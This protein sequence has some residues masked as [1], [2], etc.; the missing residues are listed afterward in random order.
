MSFFST[1]PQ[2]LSRITSGGRFIGEVDGLRFL[3]IFPV[4]VQHLSERLQRYGNADFENVKELSFAA[5]TASRGFIGV[6]IFFA[7]SGFILALPFANHY[8]NDTRK[9]RLK[10]YFV[11]RL[12]RLEPPYIFFMTL[13]FLI[14]LVMNRYPLQ[15]LFPHYLASIFYVHNLVYDAYSMI[16][17][18]AWTLEIEVQ[19]YI[20]APLLAAVF[21]RLKS[22]FLRRL[23]LV[24]SIFVLLTAQLYFGW[25]HMP[26][27]ITLLNNLHLFLTGFLVAD[28]YVKT[29]S[30]F[31]SKS[32]WF[33]LLF[34]LVLPPLFF[35]WGYEAEKWYLFPFLLF[36]V[37]ISVFKSK[38]VNRF[39]TNPWIM[40]TGG[41]CYTIYLIHLPL[42]EFQIRLTKNLII[43]DVFWVNLLVQLLIYLPLV[44][45]VS[46]VFFLLIEKPCMDKEW[47]QKL[48][49][50]LQGNKVI[51]KPSPSAAKTKDEKVTG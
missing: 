36:L 19:F 49:A 5:F 46:A 1:L 35:Y 17:P 4:L 25:Y 10:N 26:Y 48:K 8:L 38:L 9:P 23:I 24:A 45:A 28:L 6:Y 7:I 50:Y 34:L 13:F 43:G 16:N 3:A 30:F 41:M 18:V 40:V 20:L 14:L 47:P 22:D 51:S 42:A 12:T 37:F 29:P 33:D 15:E 11:R 27:K 39:F 31:S 21:F 2:R 44:F 32:F